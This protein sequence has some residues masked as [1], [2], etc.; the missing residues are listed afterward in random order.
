MKNNYFTVAYGYQIN[1][2]QCIYLLYKIIPD[3]PEF[4]KIIPARYL[5][6]TVSTLINDVIE[7][8]RK[9][10]LDTRNKN[11]VNI[12]RGNI[13]YNRT[14]AKYVDFIDKMKSKQSKYEI[15]LYKNTQISETCNKKFLISLK[16]KTLKLTSQDRRITLNSERKK[17]VKL[18]SREK[19]T[20]K[21]FI[22]SVST[23][24]KLILFIHSLRT[25]RNFEKEI[26]FRKGN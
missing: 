5:G 8:A 4:S 13:N 2:G 22:S 23:D 24:N 1:I 10:M 19:E 15:T 3:N 21:N 26:R 12:L 17:Y 6:G 7:I 14:V 20:F 16:S 25:S 9:N 18:V 11:L